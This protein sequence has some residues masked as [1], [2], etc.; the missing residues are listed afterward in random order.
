MKIFTG[1]MACVL[2]CGVAAAQDLAGLPDLDVPAIKAENALWVENPVEKQFLAS[3]TVV[4]ADLK[5]PG[6]IEMMHFAMPGSLKLGREAILRIYWDGAP[7]PSVNCPLV[8]FF[9]N[10]A[11]QYDSVETVVSNVRRG[12]NCY[13]PMP[14]R[15]SARVEVVYDGDLAPGPELQ[16]KMP[17][18][19]YVMYRNL[20]QVSD[21]AGYFHANWRQDALPLG[22]V[23]YTALETSGKGKFV[24]WSVTVRKPGSPAYLVD[25]NEMFYIDGESSPSIELQGIEDSFGFSWGFPE[26]QSEFLVSGY[27]KYFQGA[28]A[29]KFFVNDAIPFEKS[30]RVAI[31]FGKNENETIKGMVGE[32]GYYHE[33][34]SVCYWYQQTPAAVGNLPSLTERQP[35]P[36]DNPAW[37]L[38]E[39]LPSESELQKQG[40]AF[41][42]LCG[43]EKKEVLYAEDGFSLG[44]VDGYGYAGW[45]G[46]VYHTRASKEVLSIELKVPASA[47]GVLRLYIIDPD[48]FGGG[49]KEAIRVDGKALGVFEGFKRGQW[50]EMPVDAASTQ[51]G[52]VLVEAENL[53]PE[54]NAVISILEW[55]KK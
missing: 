55:R 53:N 17:C 41:Y 39:V 46:P 10:P 1:V 43:R 37:P 38:K 2:V 15:K 5:G 52:T 18:Y 34:S 47:A 26:T 35:A 4:V 51:D 8:D 48:G 31:D 16:S 7:E 28:A 32:E 40:T 6:R 27:R 24:G 44:K 19:S 9:C 20:D 12:F 33:F 50:I 22:K 14:Y 3:K 54:G 23:A 21:S 36:D 13:W 49:R 11:G 29:Y 25:M 45:P 42:M 30:L